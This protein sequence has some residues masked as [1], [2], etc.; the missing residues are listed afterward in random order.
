MGRKSALGLAAVALLLLAP[1]A[2]GGAVCSWA[3]SS[4][5][6]F[7]Q[8]SWSGGATPTPS[9]YAYIVNGGTA[10]VGAT[11]L[12][13]CNTLMLGTTAGAGAL[14][15]SGG[16]LSAPYQH[17]GDSG[18]GNFVQLGGTNSVGWYL[19][20]GYSSS[21]S[22]NYTLGGGSLSVVNSPG[23]EYLGYSGTGTFT[24]T[25][26]TNSVWDGSNP[27]GYS[28]CLGY[29]PS[30]SG[31]YSLSQTG[32][33]SAPYQYLGYSGGGSF[34]QSGG[35][36]SASE[37]IYLGYNGPSGSSPASNGTY[38]LIGP[39]VL[40]AGVLVV[41]NS[42][43]GNFTQSDGSN[44]PGDLYLGDVF[45]G[46]GE[47][48]LSATGRLSAAYEYVG[49]GG[50][51]S[52]TQSGG[53][54]TV[55]NLFLALNGSAAGTYN[56][57]GGT[58]VVS[59]LSQGA[60]SAAFNFNGGTLMAGTTFSTSLPIALATAGGNAT[61]DTNGCILTLSGILSG[62]GNLVKTDGGKL[63]LTAANTFSG[64]TTVSGGTLTL[65]NSAALQQS[66]LDTSGA[67][68]LSFG[69]LTAAMLGGLQGTGSLALNTTA[70]KG[71]ALTVGNNNASTTF[72][73]AL[74]GSGSLSKVGSGTLV[75]SGS[76]HYS[77]GTSVGGGVLSAQNAAAIPAGSLL[78]IGAG[79]SLVLGNPA[80][81]ESV[82]LVGGDP[83]AGPLAGPSI[84]Q[85]AGTPAGG[86]VQGVPEPATLALLFAA[87]AGGLVLRAR[88]A[89][90]RP[91]R[92]L[93]A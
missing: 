30:G 17:V 20:L 26:G 4:A 34:T 23:A 7:G 41:G 58:L 25:G 11:E 9:D 44:N 53:T 47:Y 38:S 81:A 32:Y 1:A 67:G 89:L 73:G 65:G 31:T 51:G 92:P 13:T 84:S 63:I 62:P 85:A 21:G 6:W 33:L 45:G 83:P 37:Y 86:P 68:V 18:S 14:Q 42:G 59:G 40:S 93:T 64:G 80:Y 66:T 55:G 72:S 24:Q 50:T 48:N 61:I 60:G 78:A 36:N 28:L 15:M 54:N 90:A 69:S 74:S 43:G 57:N 71:V 10:T 82:S 79:G 52:C 29:N 39:G 88:R 2:A 8:N 77:G 76:D 12:P 56:L 49:Y 91:R 22:G 75:L 16:Y 35:S 87:A 70:A 5:D 46:S 3:A 19:Y 27:I